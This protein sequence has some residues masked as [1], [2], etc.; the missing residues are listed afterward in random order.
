MIERPIGSRWSYWDINRAGAEPCVVIDRYDEIEK[1][2]YDCAVE[3]ND[4]T[5]ALAQDHHL[6]ALDCLGASPE[7]ICRCGADEAAPDSRLRRH[8]R[9]RDR[10]MSRIVRET[11]EL[12][13]SVAQTP[14]G[15]KPTVFGGRLPYRREA[16]RGYMATGQ[17]THPAGFRGNTAK[18]PVHYPTR[19]EA[20]AWAD[21]N[22]AAWTADPVPTK[23]S[24]RIA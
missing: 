2:Q 21:A 22:R 10:I 19:D 9:T 13:M 18:L 16:I 14:D 23:K 1:A 24:K 6:H 17:V 3:F 20:E 12:A 15:P 8:V 11:G 5:R 4:G 7:G